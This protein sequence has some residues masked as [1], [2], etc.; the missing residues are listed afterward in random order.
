[1]F[2]LS[3]LTFV[4]V[5][6]HLLSSLICLE[7]MTLII[8]LKISLISFSF[9]YE[10]F[11]CFMYISIAVC[12]AALGLSIVILYTLKKGNEMIKPL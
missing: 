10:T 9:P 8:Y 7:C 3:M 1:M 5:F 11:Y 4:F 2:F 12:E 6:K